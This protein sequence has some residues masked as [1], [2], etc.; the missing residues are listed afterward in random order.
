MTSSEKSTL[1]PGAITAAAAQVGNSF[2]G[3]PGRGRE[4]ARLAVVGAKFNGAVTERLLAGVL[5]AFR[6]QG[7]ARESVTLAWVPGSF[8][9]PLVAQCFAVS[10]EVDAVVVL[11]AVIRG[12]TPHFDFVAGQCAA[13][14]QR[15]ALTTGVPIVFGVLTTDDVEQAMERSAPGTTNRGYQAGLTALEMCDLMGKLPALPVPVV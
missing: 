3:D 6:S 1:A 8:E 13:G 15:V 14:C 7:V 9:L 5:E 4:C 11:G 10:G 2:A 12:E